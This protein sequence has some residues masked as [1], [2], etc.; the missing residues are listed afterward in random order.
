MEITEVGIHDTPIIQVTDNTTISLGRENNIRFLRVSTNTGLEIVRRTT[1]LSM[2]KLP[3]EIRADI[4]KVK[5]SSMK[6]IF[7]EMM[8]GES[9]PREKYLELKKKLETL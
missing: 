2:T 1:N 8:K 9:I 3:K 6:K 5:L 4:G 7:K